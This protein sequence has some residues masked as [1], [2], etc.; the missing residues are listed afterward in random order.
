MHTHSTGHALPASLSTSGQPG[1]HSSMQSLGEGSPFIYTTLIIV[2]C[3][4]NCF[5]LSTAIPVAGTVLMSLDLITSA[6][7]RPPGSCMSK[8]EVE[9]IHD[10]FSLDHP[11]LQSGLPPGASDVCDQESRHVEA[12]ACYTKYRYP[13]LCDMYAVCS[14]WSQFT[15][16]RTRRNTT[17]EQRTP[18]KLLRNREESGAIWSSHRNLR[19]GRSAERRRHADPCGCS[20]ISEA[21]A[22][23]IGSPPFQPSEVMS[24]AVYVP[25]LREID[26]L[27]CPARELLL[28]EGIFLSVIGA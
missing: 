7:G 24:S 15:Y 2:T 6:S 3:F 19:L 8:C 9:L 12:L 11:S 14:M 5:T 4:F 28:V 1:T 18:N 25:P 17:K 22:H 27:E 16:I 10:K 20:P 21:S 26:R 13:H 23:T